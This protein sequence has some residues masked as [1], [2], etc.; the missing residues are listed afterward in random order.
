MSRHRGLVSVCPHTY[1]RARSRQNFIPMNISILVIVDLQFS[2]KF[3]V[4]T[5]KV[6][7]ITL[8]GDIHTCSTHSIRAGVV[9]TVPQNVS[10]RYYEPTYCSL[11]APKYELRK[12][13]LSCGGQVN[14]LGGTSC[15]ICSQSSGGSGDKSMSY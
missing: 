12:V 7:I 1:G 8:D 14:Q 9:L 6:V 15:A 2:I 10:F 5:V 3:S 13:L 4:H 11:C